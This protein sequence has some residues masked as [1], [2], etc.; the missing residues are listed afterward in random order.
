MTYYAALDVS[1]RTVNICIV[2]EADTQNL[3]IKFRIG[4]NRSD[5]QIWQ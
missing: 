2:D 3:L 4:V 5:L 1:L